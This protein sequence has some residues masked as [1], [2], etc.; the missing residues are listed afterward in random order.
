MTTEREYPYFIVPN[1][2]GAWDGSYS[3]AHVE[4]AGARKHLAELHASGPLGL[5]MAI[6]QRNPAFAAGEA[7]SGNPRLIPMAD[8]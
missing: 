7:S 3:Y 1:R 8:A 2:S 5:R 4:L 6:C